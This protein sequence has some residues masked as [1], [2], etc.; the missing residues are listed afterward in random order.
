MIQLEGQTF[1]FKI[2]Y[3]DLNLEY[4]SEDPADPAKTKR[5]LILMLAE[6]Y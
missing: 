1:Y 5:V 4:R 3:Y 6:E 2:D